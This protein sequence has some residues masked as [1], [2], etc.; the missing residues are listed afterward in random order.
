[1]NEEM[2]EREVIYHYLET[3]EAEM[4]VDGELTVLNTFLPVSEEPYTANDYGNARRFLDRYGAAVRYCPEEKR[5]YLFNGTKWAPVPVEEVQKRIRNA[6]FQSH[7]EERAKL[8]AEQ[9]YKEAAKSEDAKVS[10]GRM[11]SIKSCMEAA[12]LD[13]FIHPQDFDADIYRFHAANGSIH[14]KT[15]EGTWFHRTGDFHT[16][17]AR[18]SLRKGSQDAQDDCPMWV[19]FVKQCCM[20]DEDLYKYVQA[21]AGYSILTGDIR[22]QKVFCLLGSGR[23]GK[24]LFINVLAH[25]AGDYARKLESSVLCTDRFGK[26][27]DETE[28]EL[29]RI[30]G[31]R[32]VYSNEFSQSSIL[33]ESFLKTITDGGLITCRPMYRES[34]EYM[35]TYT[36]WFSTNHM[37][38]LQ[39]MDE[40][41]RRRI[42]VIPFR[43]HLREDEVD[44]NLEA[45]LLSETDAILRWLIQGYLRYHHQG[46][47][48]PKAVIEATRGYFEEQD[49]VRRFVDEYYVEN[50]AGRIYARDIYADYKHW[51]AENGEEVRSQKYLGIEMQR[52]AIRKEKDDKGNFYRVRRKTEGF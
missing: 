33:N 41:I 11:S 28:K 19:R 32:F 31:S 27:S 21:A 6:L 7:E 4:A 43:N 5:W 49:P 15:F 47:V 26:K 24:S 44:R 39:A 12:A 2:Q 38:G 52:L 17:T 37:P 40:G 18:A 48:P 45:K 46:L 22:E 10:C 36:L 34:I 1:M 20:Y 35:P 3:P 25:V 23:N 8:E 14:L 50:P 16:K 9:R 13:C 30:R 51:C 29:Y 42:V